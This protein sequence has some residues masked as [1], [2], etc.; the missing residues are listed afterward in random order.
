M[1]S[2][3]RFAECLLKDCAEPGEPQRGCEVAA[4]LQREGVNLR[5]V[6]MALEVYVNVKGRSIRDERKK[7]AKQ[8]RAIFNKG[9]R[10]H[11]VPPEVGRMLL[12]RSELAR[13]TD[14]LSRVH[15][16][17]ALA[18]LH[19]YLELATGR[20]VTMSELAF[21]VEAGNRALGRKPFDV[22][23]HSIR[24]ELRRHR[25]RFPVFHKILKDQITRNL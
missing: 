19:I 7:H 8:D 18:G 21:L 14:G 22:D 24:E 13:S 1:D 5:S 3:D 16:T 23:P 20:R 9:V 11:G 15:N 25:K 2:F 12:D 17:D 6:W 4:Q 10:D